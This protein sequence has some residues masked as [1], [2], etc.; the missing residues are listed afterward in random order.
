MSMRLVLVAP[1]PA[2]P[3]TFNDISTTGLFRSL[4]GYCGAT[5]FTFRYC[6][7]LQRWYVYHA[8]RSE[9]VAYL[10]ELGDAAVS[11]AHPAV[12]VLLFRSPERP[13]HVWRVD[14]HTCR[15]AGDLLR[16]IAADLELTE[17]VVSPIGGASFARLTRPLSDGEAPVAGLVGYV[18]W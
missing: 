4:V 12:A 5:P 7:D 15:G 14:E 18:N 11:L 3:R 16:P 1:H 6:G 2:P 17:F 8:A 13:W 9:P 10:D